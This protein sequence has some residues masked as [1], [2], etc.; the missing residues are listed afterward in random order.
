ME[1]YIQEFI[2]YLHEEK[3][4]SRNT[5]L[6]Y[7]RDLK[8]LNIFCREQ[9][10]DSVRDITRETLEGYIG[11]LQE[12]G[13]KPATISRNIASAKAFFLYM[14]QRELIGEDPAADLKAPKIEKKAPAVLSLEETVRLLEQ[15]AGDSPKALR[16]R[17]MLELLYATGLRVSELISLRISD[18][19]LQREYMIC[20]D[21][22]RERM[23]PFGDTARDA[24]RRYLEYGRPKL[25]KDSSIDLL[26]TNC[27][28]QPM[29][30]Q[31]FWKLIKGYGKKAGIEGDLTPHTLRHSF[32]AHL[33]SNGADLHSVQ[34]MLGHSDISTTQIYAEMA[35]SKL[36]KEYKKAH[37]RG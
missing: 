2:R 23:I 11:H 35:Q 22:S 20:K 16:D 1:D 17:A 18:L 26:F 13:M 5:E 21:A 6:S 28:G 12:A 29:S 14:R 31:G 24:V 4:K 3:H 33:V 8:K 36:Q 32:A 19:D 15:P 7:A 34:E 30:R 25:V 27:S 10:V 37:P 9:H